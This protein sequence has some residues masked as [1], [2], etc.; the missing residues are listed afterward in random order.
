M[1]ALDLTP[2]GLTVYELRVLQQ[3][4]YAWELIPPPCDHLLSP[5]YTKAAERL[6][7]RGFLTKSDHQ[8]QPPGGGGF[9]PVVRLTTENF[10]AMAAALAALANATP[11]S[12]ACPGK[13]V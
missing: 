13:E 2:L 6:I 11:H 5:A 1:A 12:P 8:V 4:R 7:A 10:A 3:A 9:G